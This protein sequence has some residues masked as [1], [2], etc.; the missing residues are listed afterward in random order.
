MLALRGSKEP[1]GVH[2]KNVHPR[3]D[4]GR[5][6]GTR[7]LQQSWEL[8]DKMKK[9]LVRNEQEYVELFKNFDLTDAEDFLGVEFAFNDGTYHSDFWTSVQPINESQNVVRTIY[10]KND[11]AN[12]PEDYPCLVLLANDRSF[13]RN[14]NV[15]FQMLDFVYIGDFDEENDDER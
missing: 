9:C 10:R 4:E 12:F 15:A 11:Y 2:R 1:L 8:I 7:L 3:F 13:D 5:H 6:R 14:G